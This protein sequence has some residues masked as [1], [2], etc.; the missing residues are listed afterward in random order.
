LRALRVLRSVALVAAEDTRHTRK[1]LAHYEI[2]VPL[3]SYH[4]HNKRAS[5]EKLISRLLEG[6]DVALVSD[7]GVPAISDPGADLVRLAV[8]SG[9]RVV[10]LPGASAVTAALSVSGLSDDRF[11]FAGFLPRDNRGRAALLSEI[12][13]S[14][15]VFVLY[16]APH[17][18]RETLKAMVKAIP[19]RR[20][21]VARE[22]TKVHEEFF[23]GTVREACDEFSSREALGE[24]TIAVEGAAPGEAR[25]S[26]AV[27]APAEERE[28]MIARL[29]GQGLPVKDVAKE[30]AAAY[31]M[32]KQDAYKLVVE[33][34]KP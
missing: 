21:V 20:L 5:G 22:I 13:A 26:E 29:L 7:A 28:A 11:T 18:L 8:A 2:R 34:K 23:R 32:R 17:R 16:E 3:V 14:P 15:G 31:H 12:A 30:L 33:L 10:P 4:E 6:H 27:E 1:L 25:Q 9:I 24:I 19:D